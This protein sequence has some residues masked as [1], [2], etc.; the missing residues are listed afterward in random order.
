MI[1]QLEKQVQE[2][3]ARIRELELFCHWLVGYTAG[4]RFFSDTARDV[5]EK[6]VMVID[7]GKRNRKWWEDV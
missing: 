3:E 2:Q 5:Y 7:P 1:E 6:A 4:R